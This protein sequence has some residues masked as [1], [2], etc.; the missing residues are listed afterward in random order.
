MSLCMTAGVVSYG[1]PVISQVIT[2]RAA[3]VEADCYSFDE[4]TGSFTLKGKLDLN[5]FRGFSNDFKA[6]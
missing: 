5:V 1:A 2:A 4:T 3:E 6:K